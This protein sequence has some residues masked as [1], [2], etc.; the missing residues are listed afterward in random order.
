MHTHNVHTKYPGVQGLRRICVRLS[1]F[2]GGRRGPT[3][4][5]ELD[6][7]LLRLAARLPTNRP[8]FQRD[9]HTNL[10]ASPL[11]NTSL[12]SLWIFLKQKH[13]G[14]RLRSSQ[15]RPMVT[16]PPTSG[17]AHQGL[18]YLLTHPLGSPNKRGGIET[19][20]SLA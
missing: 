4:A 2:G 6:L 19:I 3:R 1:L 10:L 14:R 5:F 9:R 16:V 13:S 7:T 18:W 15:A 17:S 20:P 12:W 11:L 8:T